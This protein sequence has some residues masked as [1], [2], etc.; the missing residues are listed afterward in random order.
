M[1]G[2]AAGGRC[3]IVLPPL[4]SQAASF[5]SMASLQLVKWTPARRTVRVC[6]SDLGS[7]PGTWPQY[8]PAS[9]RMPPSPGRGCHRNDRLRR[10]LGWSWCGNSRCC[11]RTCGRRNRIR[12]VNLFC[13]SAMSRCKIKEIWNIHE[14]ESIFIPER[15]VCVF[16]CKGLKSFRD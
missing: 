4:S 2:I 12:V 1:A 13:L 7:G 11:R 3:K 14:N 16:D 15:L 8:V 10:T 5:A 9:D 6:G